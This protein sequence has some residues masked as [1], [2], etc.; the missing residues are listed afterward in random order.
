MFSRC[1]AWFLINKISQI[2]IAF[3]ACFVWII[4]HCR[5]C[6]L[7][8]FLLLQSVIPFCGSLPSFLNTSETFML[9]EYCLWVMGAAVTCLSADP[10]S[11]DY[12]LKLNDGVW[13]CQ[14]KMHAVPRSE[15]RGQMQCRLRP[16]TGNHNSL[17]GLLKLILAKMI[18]LWLFLKGE[19]C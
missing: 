8:F 7:R 12:E 16:P 14:L 4:S 10:L 13:D 19:P 9:K 5:F 18:L 3:I 6:A 2:E 11:P 15:P 17:L 1:G